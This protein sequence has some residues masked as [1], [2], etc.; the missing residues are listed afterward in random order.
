MLLGGLAENVTGQWTDGVLAAVNAKRGTEAPIDGFF[1]WVI[2]DVWEERD[3]RET[4]L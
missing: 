2:E 3:D 4:D 1:D